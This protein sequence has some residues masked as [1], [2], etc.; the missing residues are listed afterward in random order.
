MWLRRR[1]PKAPPKPDYVKIMNLEIEL[2]LRERPD[3]WLAYCREQ[4]ELRRR[5]A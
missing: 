3:D 2:G 4:S 1:R 5:N